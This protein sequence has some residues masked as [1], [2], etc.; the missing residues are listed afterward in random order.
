[1]THASQLKISK[2]GLRAFHKVGGFI[3][4]TTRLIQKFGS[5]A[6]RA[7]VEIKSAQLEC[8]LGG[9]SIPLDSDLDKGYVILTLGNDQ[10]LGL[11]LLINGRIR[12]QLPKK[13]IR[14]AM[15]GPGAP[16]K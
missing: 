7:R 11:G 1:M 14:K 9:E 16:L 13:E 10:I 2:S 8:L 3:K 4:P 6:T 5:Y 15:L 12:S